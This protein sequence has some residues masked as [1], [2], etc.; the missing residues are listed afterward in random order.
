MS[1][2][3]IKFVVVEKNNFC[4][5]ISRIK[6]AKL[7]IEE[8]IFHRYVTILNQVQYDR[9]VKSEVLA[10]AINNGYEDFLML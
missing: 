5:F 4:E 2:T 1:L 6:L 3:Y 9:R 7:I 8:Q 10:F